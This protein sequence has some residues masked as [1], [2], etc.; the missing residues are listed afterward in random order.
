MCR[1]VNG[2]RVRATSGTLSFLESP[3]ETGK[4]MRGLD[5]SASPLGQPSDWPEALRLVATIMLASKFPMFVAW[6]SQLGFIYN[7]PYAEILAEKH[8]SAMGRPFREIWGEIWSDIQPLIDA[9]LAGEAVYRDNLPLRMNRRGYEEDTW[10]TF[11][12]SPVRDDRGTIAGVFCAC[13]ETTDKVMAE[14]ALRESERRL[15]LAI[16]GANIGTWDWDLTTSRGSWSPARPVQ[17]TR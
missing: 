2:M 8:P 5:W 4:L 6:G 1:Y 15:K 16:E 7:D 3:S 11:S 14:S 13:V 10:F 9:T 17:R 12:Y